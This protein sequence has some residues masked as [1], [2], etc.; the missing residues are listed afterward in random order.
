MIRP[1]CHERT[2]R[3]RDAALEDRDGASVPRPPGR[4]LR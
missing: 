2:D 4:G 3:R 1:P